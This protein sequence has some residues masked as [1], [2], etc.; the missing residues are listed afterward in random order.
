VLKEDLRARIA[1]GIPLGRIGR[2]EEVAAAVRFLCSDEAAYIT[3]NVIDV[4]GGMY[5]R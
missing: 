5:M 2:P 1:A 3:G 4:N